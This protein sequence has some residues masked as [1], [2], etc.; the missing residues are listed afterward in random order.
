MKHIVNLIFEAYHLKRIP[1][2]GAQMLGGNL[3][4][5]AEHTYLTCIIG[6]ILAM[7]EGANVERTVLLCL[8]HDLP[9]SRIGDMNFIQ[10]RYQMSFEDEAIKEQVQ[11]LNTNLKN[12]LLS[13]YEEYQNRQ[14]PESKLVHEAD[15]L[16]QLI[17]EK[18]ASENGNHQAKNWL[19]YSLKQ[20]STKT[21]QLIGK[22]VLASK[23]YDWWQN[24]HQK[25]PIA[26]QSTIQKAIRILK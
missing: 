4:T 6:M 14:T 13:I 23:S 15:I 19:D 25:K 16:E 20:L 2:S 9:E 12:N 8:F 26:K 11:N 10:K 17:C 24:L 5:I 7:Q 3:G 18:V 21:G 22:E 1:R